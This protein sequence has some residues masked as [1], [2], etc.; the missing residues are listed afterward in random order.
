VKVGCIWFGAAGLHAMVGMFW[1]LE[2]AHES[3]DE[4]S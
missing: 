1:T 4:W 3:R 2:S